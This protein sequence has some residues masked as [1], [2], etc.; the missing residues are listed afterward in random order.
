MSARYWENDK[1]KLWAILASECILAGKNPLDLALVEPKRSLDDRAH[2]DDLRDVILW[3]ARTG[4]RWG[5][6][7]R[8]IEEPARPLSAFNI[9][10]GKDRI[11]WS[12][13]ILSGAEAVFRA[14]YMSERVKKEW[15]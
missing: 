2:V 13:K 7:D 9:V 3:A 5:R 14:H 1:S 8:E 12:D 4:A 15:V 6:A 10:L 11:V